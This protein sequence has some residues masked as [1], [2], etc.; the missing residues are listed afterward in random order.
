MTTTT[1]TKLFHRK[2]TRSGPLLS[3]A[4]TILAQAIA[5]AFA[6]SISVNI[7]LSIGIHSLVAIMVSIFLQLSLPWI[8][9]NGLLP[10]LPQFI[11]TLS[12]EMSVITGLFVLIALIYLPTFWTRVPYYPTAPELY[13]KILS[14]LSSK[15]EA[16]FIDLGC[17]FGSTLYW[18]AKQRREMTFYGIEAAPLP[19][20]IAKLR[21][22]FIPNLHILYGNFWKIS[23]TNYSVTYAFLSPE[24]M[25]QLWQ[26]V[27]EE[28]KPGTLFLSN[29]FPVPEVQEKA[30]IDSLLVYSV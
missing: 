24:P 30:H 9:I 28:M 25:T 7:I 23:L 12:Q 21:S 1:K 27:K 5:F 11:G 16:T 10:L 6:A 3:F 2:A 8:V 13:S 19:Y 14:V 20:I 4:M 26:K 18:L 29:H 15:K 17:G 22:F